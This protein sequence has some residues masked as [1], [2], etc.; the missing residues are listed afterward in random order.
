MTTKLFDFELWIV[1]MLTMRTVREDL[2]PIEKISKEPA[3]DQTSGFR[4]HTCTTLT[5]R[6]AR[7]L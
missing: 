3:A 1:K 7:F 6:A 2:N 4:C 5:V